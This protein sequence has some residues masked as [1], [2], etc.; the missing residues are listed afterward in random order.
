[1]LMLSKARGT[2]PRSI[3]PPIQGVP[4]AFP[5]DKWLER[6]AKHTTPCSASVNIATSHVA[7]SAVGLSDLHSAIIE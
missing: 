3:Q 7:A 1:M 4:T 2:A 6:G 5:G